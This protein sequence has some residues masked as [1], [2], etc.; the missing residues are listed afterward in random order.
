MIN[1]VYFDI[2]DNKKMYF[3]FTSLWLSMRLVVKF[4]SSML[5][6]TTCTLSLTKV[7]I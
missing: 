2:G 5:S 6:L 3:N 4:Y 7:I 1:L